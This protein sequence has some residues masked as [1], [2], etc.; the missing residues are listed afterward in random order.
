[1]H[2]AS[3]FQGRGASVSRLAAA[4]QEVFRCRNVAFILAGRDLKLRYRQTFMGSLWAILQPL[5]VAA[6]FS[7]FFGHLAHVSSD[8]IPYMAFVLAGAVCWNYVSGAVSEAALSLVND[9]ALVTKVYFPRVLAPMASILPGLVDFAVA[10]VPLGVVMALQG[11][12]VGPALILMPLWIV[13]LIAVASTAG[14]WLS[15]LNARYRDV[16]YV[17]PLLLQLWLFVSPVIYPVSYVPHGWRYLYAI[18]PLVGALSGFRWSV[19]GAPFPGTYLIVSAAA[20]VFFACL[21]GAYFHRAQ[22]EL[23][24]VI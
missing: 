23:A 10:L 17:L 22:Q 8:G 14:L 15:A 9:R 5:S 1:M 11:V 13:F 6:V 24:D 4:G 16:R 3:E 2:E 21:A 7:V 12:S 18:N 20:L 19:L